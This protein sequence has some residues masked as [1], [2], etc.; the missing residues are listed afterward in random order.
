MNRRIT[1]CLLLG[2]IGALVG[3]DIYVAIAEPGATISA[4]TLDFAQQHPVIPFSVGVVAGH[5]FWRQRGA[6]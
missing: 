4:L 3:W 1:L 5:I 6:R 2:C